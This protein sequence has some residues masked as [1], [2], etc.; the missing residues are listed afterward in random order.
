M[1]TVA[2]RWMPH[3][4]P[5]RRN[6]YGHDMRTISLL[7]A[8]FRRTHCH[9]L[10]VRLQP[11]EA[12]KPERVPTDDQPLV[13]NPRGFSVIGSCTGND[14]RTRSNNFSKA[15]PT[16]VTSHHGSAQRHDYRIRKP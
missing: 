7:R 14:W 12:L 1:P 9:K 8:P 13:T 2:A 11:S 4:K 3:T 10:D 16:S 15:G 5:C 6:D